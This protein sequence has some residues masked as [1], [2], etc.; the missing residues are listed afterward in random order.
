M[1]DERGLDV[2]QFS[3]RGKRHMKTGLPCQDAC[4]TCVTPDGFT[5]MAVAD[6]VGSSA[7]S[8][9][10][11]KIA[12]HAVCDFFK[13]YAS[14]FAD[15]EDMRCALYASMSYALAQVEQE[16]AKQDIPFSFETT[17]EI[18]VLAEDGRLFYAH[19]GD[20]GI[21]AVTGE[22]GV[23]LQTE[24]MRDPEGGRVICLGGGAS[25]WVF[26][27]A[28][29]RAAFALIVTDGVNDVLLSEWG[30]Q[31][32]LVLRLL[33]GQREAEA[34][35]ESAAEG[36]RRAIESKT[37]TVFQAVKDDIT[38][39]V[40]RTAGWPERPPKP[41]KG[42][43]RRKTKDRTL[44]WVKQTIHHLQRKGRKDNGLPD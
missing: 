18:A 23:Y 33:D 17:L 10:A 9:Q 8:D 11:S 14:P 4:E 16:K 32:A 15:E 12:V 26:G 30:R 41:K 21:W 44:P 38:V 19:A 28:K 22:L 36:W 35:G 39:S 20:G 6:G 31:K 1:S 24:R 29:Q 5:V 37:G 7:Q 3:L 25:N 13:E 34:H 2:R 27:A 40:A 42:A 43:G